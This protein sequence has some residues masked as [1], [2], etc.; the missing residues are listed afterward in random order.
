[1]GRQVSQTFSWTMVQPILDPSNLRSNQCGQIP[2]LG[3]I[4]SDQSVS[5]LIGAALPR[6]IRIGEVES[7]IEHCADS[8]MIGKFLA[9]VGSDAKDSP[10]QR[11]QPILKLSCGRLRCAAV[12]LG[13]A[14]Q[15]RA[16][17]H[18]CQAGTLSSFPDYGVHFPVTHFSTRIRGGGA[19]LDPD[20]TDDLAAPLSTTS[21]ALSALPLAA[22]MRVQIAS[23]PLVRVDQLVDPL[24]TDP[25]GAFQPS[26]GCN[27]F[28]APVTANESRNSAPLCRCDAVP[29]P[30]GTSPRLSPLLGLLGAISALPAIA[31]N[32]ARN[33]AGAAINR[34]RDVSEAISGSQHGPNLVTFFLGEV[35]I[36]HRATPTWWLECR[37]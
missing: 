12:E 35:R 8:L 14:N 27:L 29:T 10:G 19:L 2:I 25:H 1:M 26:S 11:F 16:A 22:Q 18:G 13:D 20:A 28:R 24:M 7:A 23:K 34:L 9:V 31:L 15:S 33:A 3:Q 30:T 17:I 21:V 36:A 5:V 32:L 6:C 37:C 4:L